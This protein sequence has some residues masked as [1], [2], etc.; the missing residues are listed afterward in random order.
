M[1]EFVNYARANPGKLT[2]ASSGP[3]TGSQVEME[4]L[5]R[6]LNIDVLEIPYKSTSQAV[7]DLLGGQ[8]SAYTAALPSVAQHVRSG[9][10][11]AIAL[12]S[13]ARSPL[14]PDIQ[15]VP[16]GLGRPDYVSSPNW[17]ALYA[18]SRTP[19]SIV[20]VLQKQVQQIMRSPAMRE[21][22]EGFG[23]QSVD[24]TVEDLTAQMHS[25][26]RRYIEVGKV[27]GL[28]K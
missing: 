22:L 17:Y 25:D 11:R 28:R 15:S 10:A 26:V 7:T 2:Y 27:L 1:K 16:E 3:G 23:A 5:K 18:H 21:Q 4:L 9:R 13:M 19:S 12:V 8:V 6:A 20:T 14:F 24:S